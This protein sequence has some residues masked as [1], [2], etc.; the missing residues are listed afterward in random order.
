MPGISKNGGND[1]HEMHLLRFPSAPDF[2]AIR[3]DSD[4]QLRLTLRDAAVERAE[5]LT[6]TEIALPE[7]FGDAG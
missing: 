1:P 7:H 3:N 4:L 2:D 6:L 5:L